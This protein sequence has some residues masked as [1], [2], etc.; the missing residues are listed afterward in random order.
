MRSPPIHNLPAQS[1]PLPLSCRD[2][3]YVRVSQAFILT[4]CLLVC[5]TILALGSR[6]PSSF[7]FTRRLFLRVH[8]KSVSLLIV[9]SEMVMVIAFISQSLP[10]LSPPDAFLFTHLAEGFPPPPKARR[11]SWIPLPPPQSLT[12]GVLLPPPFF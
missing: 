9:L 1:F 10:S 11:S 8:R 5:E 4:H 7:F 2:N 12:L 6:S 3:I